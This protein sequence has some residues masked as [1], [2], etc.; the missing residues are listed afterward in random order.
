M[1]YRDTKYASDIQKD[2]NNASKKN[3]S[4]YKNALSKRK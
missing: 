4:A 1:A 2:Y 3:E